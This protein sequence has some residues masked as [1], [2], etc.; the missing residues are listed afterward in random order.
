MSMRRWLV[1]VVSVVTLLAVP[2]G[3]GVGYATGLAIAETNSRRASSTVGV[4]HAGQRSGIANS[5]RQR[6]LT[7]SPRSSGPNATATRLSAARP[8]AR[9]AAASGR[10]HCDAGA[11]LSV[12]HTT[13]T[14]PRA[15]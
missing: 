5:S 12:R 11:C 8:I 10:T 7:S 13:S 3:A 1:A 4:P 2:L 6:R 15:R 14:G 9:R